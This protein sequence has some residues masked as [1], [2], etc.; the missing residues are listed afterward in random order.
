MIFS[1]IS[2]R[3]SPEVFPGLPQEFLPRFLHE[4]LLKFLQDYVARLDQNFICFRPGISPKMLQRVPSGISSGV[5]S[6]IHLGNP[7]AIAQRTSSRINPPT[8]SVNRPET[9]PEVS[10]ELAIT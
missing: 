8:F 9:S 5:L 4:L 6:G 1:E 2:T 3:I 7:S 10:A